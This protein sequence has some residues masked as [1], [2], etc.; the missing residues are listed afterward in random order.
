MDR[1]EIKNKIKEM[2]LE[3]EGI[4]TI[5]LDCENCPFVDAMQCNYEMMA[6]FLVQNSATFKGEL[7]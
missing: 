6:E 2:L 5:T 4:C 1:N 3:A 7:E